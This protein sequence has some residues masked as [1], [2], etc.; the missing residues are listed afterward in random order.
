[1]LFQNLREHLI[2]SK[3]ISFAENIISWNNIKSLESIEYDGSGE[4]LK[5]IL[6]TS[7]RDGISGFEGVKVDNDK[8]VGTFIDI[9]NSKLTKRY[10]FTL[11]EN[12]ISYKLLNPKDIDDNGNYSEITFATKKKDAK[13]KNCAKSTPCG[14]SCIKKG[15]TCR[16][17]PSPQQKEVIKKIKNNAQK[18][19][20]S[21][22]ADVATSELNLDPSRFQYKLVHSKSGS[23]GSL[24]GVRK[25][26]PELAGIIQVWEDP[27]DGKTYV[28]NGH[29]RANLAKEQGVDEVTVRYIKA[30]S[31]E[32][33]RATGALTNI[34]EGRGTPLDAAKFFRDTGL[35]QKDLDDKGIP[36][37][38]KI[39]TDG[40]ALASLNDGLFNRVVTGEFPQE[41]A[42]VIGGMI[43]DAKQ[44][45]E[46]VELIEKHEKRGKKVTNDTI[47]ELADMVNSA[48]KV[49]EEDGGLLGL[50]GFEPGQRSLAIEKAEIQ[51]EI[52]RRLSREKKLFGIV[53]KSTTAKELEKAGNQI[54]IDKSREVSESADI[55]LRVFD[56]EKA[57]TGAISEAINRAAT[58]IAD[59]ENAKKVKDEI[60]AEVLGRIQETYAGGK[61]KNTRRSK[62]SDDREEDEPKLF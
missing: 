46:L 36:L 4:Q 8:I 6:E 27:A 30:K 22:V 58:R 38:E 31:A 62:T 18:R 11:D 10:K 26:D 14:N 45:A 34:A 24:T 49:Q 33:A 19:L 15:L 56:Q 9:V 35:T 44:Q 28:I 53:G 48:P 51:S 25:W 55:A 13:S 42:V 52:K 17:T 61:T 37:R 39:A 20:R 29:N 32:E 47:K 59:G 60:Y 12:E 16:V 50:L 54:D 57:F 41:R 7:Y 3:G 1:M 5:E 2:E 23:S 21:G 43:K 40:I